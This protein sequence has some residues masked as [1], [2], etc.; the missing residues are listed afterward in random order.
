MKVKGYVIKDSD[1]KVV[2]LEK[3]GL[4]KNLKTGNFIPKSISDPKKEVIV[5]EWEDLILLH[6]RR[7]PHRYVNKDS[8]EEITFTSYKDKLNKLLE[9]TTDRCDYGEMEWESLEDEFAYRKF[10]S[11]HE[12]LYKTVYE[13]EEIVVEKIKEVSLETGNPFIKSLFCEGHKYHEIDV[14]EY[15]RPSACKD[16]L[17]NKM[18]ELGVKYIGDRSWINGNDLREKEW[19]NSSHSGIRF[20]RLSGKYIFGREWEIKHSPKGTL[21]NMRGMYAKDKKA[22]EETVNL[23]YKKIFGEFDNANTKYV[24]NSLKIISDIQGLLE[25]V[26]VYKKS[27]DNYF[28]AVHKINSLEKQLSKVLKT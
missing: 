27:S 7:I 18:K 12:T 8:L 4:Y 21:E 2:I 3:A 19:D 17:K 25:Y 5:E 20:A 26:E 15:D 11:S 24:V 23:Q 22:I 16:I 10:V 9:K 14:F 13:E 6:K 28:K 1:T